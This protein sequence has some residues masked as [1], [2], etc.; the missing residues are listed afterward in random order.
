M[1]NF[2]Q[3]VYAF[4]N[5]RHGTELASKSWEDVYDPDFPLMMAIFDLLLCI[6]P[7]SVRCETTF[8]QMKLIKTSRRTNLKPST[9][10]DLLTVKIESSPVEEYDPEP[11]LNVWLVCYQSFEKNK[12]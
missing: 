8:S 4:K 12:I 1:Q 11:A 2:N 10:N 6:P 7:T 3:F 9:L 5:T